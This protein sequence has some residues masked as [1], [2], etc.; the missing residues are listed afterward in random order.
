MP[1]VWLAIAI[2]I[3]TIAGC[4]ITI[5]LAQRHRDESLPVGDSVLNVPLGNVSSQQAET[6][7]DSVSAPAGP[8][9]NERSAPGS[10]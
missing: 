9:E 2:V 3:A 7:D 10:H 4:I 5:V 1:V 8:S 6:R